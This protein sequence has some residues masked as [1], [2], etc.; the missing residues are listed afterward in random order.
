[1]SQSNTQLVRG[2]LEGE[3]NCSILIDF[4]MTQQFI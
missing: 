2:S 3:V 1:M 4:Y